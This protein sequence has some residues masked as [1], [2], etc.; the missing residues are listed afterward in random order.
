[1]KSGS[2]KTEMPVTISSSHLPEASVLEE[3]R[4]QER[5]IWTPLVCVKAL[6]NH[7]HNVLTIMAEENTSLITDS[8]IVYNNRRNDRRTYVVF[9]LLSN[10]SRIFDFRCRIYFKSAQFN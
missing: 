6:L 8:G 3:K 2:S 1:M 5:Q 4:S 10:F 9:K 7:L